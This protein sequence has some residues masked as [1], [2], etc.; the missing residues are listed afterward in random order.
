LLQQVFKILLCI[1][2]PNVSLVI[3]SL[4]TN[5]LVL[6]LVHRKK[7]ELFVVV[8][9]KILMIQSKEIKSLHSLFDNG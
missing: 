7:N 1:I 6:A 3:A 4:S 5:I 9:S 8:D 2:T